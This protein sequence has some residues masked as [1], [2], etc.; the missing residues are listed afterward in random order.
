MLGT[1]MWS[2]R[3][4]A[5]A[6]TLREHCISRLRVLRKHE[7]NTQPKNFNGNLPLHIS[8]TYYLTREITTLLSA[9]NTQQPLRYEMHWL[10]GT[11]LAIVGICPA[12][13]F[14]GMASRTFGIQPDTNAAL[15]FGAVS[16]GIVAW[17][18]FRGRG[19]ELVTT[20]DFGSVIH[21]CIIVFGISIGA[22]A[23]IMLFRAI[24]TAPNPGVVMGVFNTNAL[25]LFLFAPLL[26][27][28]MPKYFPAAE[29]T[30]RDFLGILLVIVGLFIIA[31]KIPK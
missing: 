24:D 13:I 23:N 18:I 4:Q 14:I 17:I 22:F 26:A 7:R 3:V 10:L 25:L 2:S 31:S 6:Q 29:I 11:I 21:I 20:A 27:F 28:L 19:N 12:F 15:Y 9:R 1:K 30:L 8:S 16:V 5:V